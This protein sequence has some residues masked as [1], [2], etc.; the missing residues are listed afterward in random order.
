MQLFS[1][2]QDLCKAHS[3]LDTTHFIWVLTLFVGLRS[4]VYDFRFD[5]F[6]FYLFIPWYGEFIKRL[7]SPGQ[8]FH[9]FKQPKGS[10]LYSQQPPTGPYPEPV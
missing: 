8:K 1:F 2:A 4:K 10:L 7:S 3:K 9:A 5:L 6:T